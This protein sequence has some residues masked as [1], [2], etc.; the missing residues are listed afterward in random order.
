MR[1][2]VCFRADRLR[3]ERLLLPT[4]G[5][6]LSNLIHAVF[7]SENVS[8]SIVCEGSSV[9]CIELVK[10]GMGESLHAR[11]F[12]EKLPQDA[13]IS[14]AEISPEL[15]FT[16]G[17]GHRELENLSH[18]ERLYLSYMKRYALDNSVLEL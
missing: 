9:G 12:A 3:S 5:G 2:H 4:R 11:E 15:S 17:L 16:Y 14:C 6:S 10:S 13:E 7:R 1:L 8:P 18:D